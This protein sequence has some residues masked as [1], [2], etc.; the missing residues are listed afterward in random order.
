MFTKHKR[1]TCAF[2]RYSTD[3]DRLST[4]LICFF[5]LTAVALLNTSVLS[6]SFVSSFANRLSYFHSSL[7]FSLLSANIFLEIYFSIWSQLF[8]NQFIF[9]LFLRFCKLT[10]CLLNSP[11]CVYKNFIVFFD[12]VDNLFLIFVNVC[13][14]FFLSSVFRF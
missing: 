13:V 3:V 1:E 10:N 12:I 5:Q 4:D 8:Y 6:F 7:S 11:K 2:E 14:Y 9:Q